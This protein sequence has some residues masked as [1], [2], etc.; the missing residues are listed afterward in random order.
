M[1]SSQRYQEAGVDQAVADAFA[2]SLQEKVGRG[3]G[4]IAGIGS[5]AAALEIPAG[6]EN[7][8]VVSACDGVGTKAILLRQDGRLATSGRDLVAA[9]V[10]DIACLGARPWY[11][12]DYYGCEGI[13]VSE[14][15]EVMGGILEA[16]AEA[17]CEL[18]GGETAQLPGMLAKGGVEL[19]GFAAGLAS[20]DSMLGPARVEDGDALVGII[21]EG[22]HCNGYSLVRKVLEEGGSSLGDRL[23][24]GTLADALLAPTPIYSSAVTALMETGVGLRAAA[25][26]TGGGLAANLSRALPQWAGAR[27]ARSAWRWGA[28]HEWLATSGGIDEAQMLE[29][30]NG[31]VG[32]VL[33]VAEEDTELVQEALAGLGHDSRALGA[34]EEGGGVRVV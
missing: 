24:A 16:C 18:V 17:G 30:T 31:G 9:C 21:A 5:F 25:H 26:V 32:M 23:G 11:F 13:D 33:V 4:T 15:E 7:P 14:A 22:L 34:V 29:S 20:K 12:L 1:A 6:I 8:V 10:N 2:R 28:A 27:V 3:P 19:V